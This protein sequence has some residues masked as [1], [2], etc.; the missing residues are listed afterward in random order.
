[1]LNTKELITRTR[2]N[3]AYKY[4]P[5]E[6]EQILKIVV[7]TILDATSNGEDVS[8]HGLG[9]FHARFIK[10]KKIGNT[11]IA[12]LKGKEFTIPNRYHLGFKPSDAANR[13]VGKLIDKI[14]KKPE[15]K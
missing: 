15:E 4:K 7:D 10:G 14:D 12:W 13:I 5:A 1:M 3:L 8:L 2:A 11:G 6:I 9:K